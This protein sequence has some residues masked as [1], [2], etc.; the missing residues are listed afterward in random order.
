MEN[1]H[2]SALMAKHAG[3]DARIKAESS[4]PLPDMTLVATLK[5]QKL[6]LKEE[7]AQTH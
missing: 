5:K 6:R 3:L 4:R 1:S 7:M 2:I